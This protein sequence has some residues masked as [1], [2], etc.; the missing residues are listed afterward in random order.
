[1]L[2]IKPLRYFVA[3][4][5]TRHF[6]R[7]A[8]QLH[9]SQP[10]L[11]RQLAA[12]EAALGVTLVRRNSRSVELTAAG[13]RFY[14]DA[15]VILAAT[16]QA[17]RNA[18]AAADGEA[19][20]LTV[21]FT[22]CA[23]YSVVPGYARVYGAAYPDVTLQLREV[24]S[25]DLPAQLLSGR[26]DA[27]IMFPGGPHDELSRRT[28]V[29]EPLCVALSRGHPLARARRLD[30]TQLAH[31]PFVVAASEVAPALHAAIMSH[32]R[33]G[34]FEPDV[35]LEVHLQQT[36]LSLVNEGVG[37]ALVPASMR[38]AQMEGVVMRPLADAPLIE[39]VLAW[40][41]LNRNPCLT[42]F[43]DVATAV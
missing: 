41:A 40:S 19:G 4:A 15:K 33:Q 25:N 23:A 1:V 27:A 5:E 18:R 7:A 31:E 9:L 30:V 37:V 36:L 8:A 21:G 22:M 38:K 11:S 39:L 20:T 29:R 16:D 14:T 26:I 34:G 24:V 17:G 3:L 35:R 6:G 10:P 2:D 12:L 32:C 43:L 42:H 28:V 13:Q